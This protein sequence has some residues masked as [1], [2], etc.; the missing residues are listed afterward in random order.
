VLGKGGGNQKGLLE[1]M[2]SQRNGVHAENTDL[3][4]KNEKNAASAKEGPL[5]SSALGDLAAPREGPLSP[6]DKGYDAG[7]SKT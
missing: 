1:P 4:K 2:T 3:K 6:G 7:Y 5:P